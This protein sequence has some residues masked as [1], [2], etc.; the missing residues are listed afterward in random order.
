MLLMTDEWDFNA[1]AITNP[2]EKETFM[3]FAYFSTFRVGKKTQMKVD[4]STTAP[5]T[6]K[7]SEAFDSQEERIIILANVRFAHKKVH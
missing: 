6:T 7:D 4:K 1:F 2:R 3:C 5:E